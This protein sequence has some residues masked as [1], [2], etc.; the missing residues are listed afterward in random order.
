MI[1]VMRASGNVGS[2]LA[3]RLLREKQDV[4]FRGTE[5]LLDTLGRERVPEDQHAIG[6][7]CSVLQVPPTKGTL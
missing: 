7:P 6:K 4:R 2:E 1:A 3:D 5:P